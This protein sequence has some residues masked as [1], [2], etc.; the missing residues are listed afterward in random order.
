MQRQYSFK[1]S[2]RVKR[3]ALEF[4]QRTGRSLIDRRGWDQFRFYAIRNGI[5]PATCISDHERRN[6]EKNDEFDKIDVSSRD[7]LRKWNAQTKVHTILDNVPEINRTMSNWMDRVQERTGV[8]LT[9]K[10]A[11][12][13]MHECF[14]NNWDLL[15][16][17]SWQAASE[18]L[19]R[20]GKLDRRVIKDRKKFDPDT[21]P[22]DMRAPGRW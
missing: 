1:V 5:L 6:L 17:E 13:I 11:Q 20:A 15:S 18:V 19:A 8:E 4:F 16:Q 22:A 2:E 7:G 14:V 12:A 21:V 10:D 9:D 3:S